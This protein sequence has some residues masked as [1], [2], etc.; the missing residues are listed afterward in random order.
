M[1]RI[2]VAEDEAAAA[3]PAR[4]LPSRGPE[5]TGASSVANLQRLVGNRAVLR[6]VGE[7]RS[8]VVGPEGGALP[9][10]LGARIDSL[11]GG[12]RRVD[13]DVSERVG[14]TLGTDLSGVRV[15]TNSEADSISRSL[16]AKAFTVGR[17]IFFSQNSYQPGSA[18][19]DRLIAHELTHVAQQ[20]GGAVQRST[21]GMMV[22]RVD[23]P[24]EAD[25]DRVA[26]QALSG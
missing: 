20:T 23:D 11:R 1:A 15:H 22:G 19:G 14:A 3:H 6:M 7:S 5:P 24:L 21:Q 4:K 8:D 12:G 13:G 9:E 2:R 17:D 26:D 10:G 18:S 16:S 25:A